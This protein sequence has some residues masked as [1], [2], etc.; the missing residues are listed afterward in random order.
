MPAAAA[1]ASHRRQPPPPLL[2]PWPRSPEP[3]RALQTFLVGPKFKGIKM[4]PPGTH[5]ISY[6]A[7]SGQGDFGA[8]TS[9]FLPIK[10]GQASRRWHKSLTE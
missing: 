2:A 3:S 7:A 9:F 8:T 4:V 10:A 6:N 5:L 1:A